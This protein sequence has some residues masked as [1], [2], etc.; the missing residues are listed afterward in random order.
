[1]DSIEAVNLPLITLMA[2]T[3]LLADKAD[4]ILAGGPGVT[5]GASAERSARQ[6]TAIGEVMES[7]RWKRLK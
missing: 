6:S 1:M 2:P 7:Q 4:L 5:G 3:P